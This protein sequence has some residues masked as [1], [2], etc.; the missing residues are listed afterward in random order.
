VTLVTRNCAINVSVT[1]AG[2]PL[3]DRLTFQAVVV[4]TI[5][6]AHFL[7]FVI[8]HSSFF[9]SSQNCLEKVKADPSFQ[10]CSWCIEDDPED[11]N[12]R[13]SNHPNTKIFGMTNKKIAVLNTK[14]FL[15][16]IN[17]GWAPD[18]FL[19]KPAY[20]VECFSMSGIKFEL[21]RQNGFTVRHIFSIGFSMEDFL[22]CYAKETISSEYLKEFVFLTNSS[23]AELVGA[24]ARVFQFSTHADILSY[25]N[26]NMELS[27]KE[28]LGLRESTPEILLDMMGEESWNRVYNTRDVSRLLTKMK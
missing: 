6:Q 22:V 18:S 24:V 12:R 9:F 10:I 14:K 27:L 20:G 28:L 19:S 2:S 13:V 11:T 25:L 23:F 17:R 4:V 26:N 7:P 1:G 21:L 15:R 5:K 16:L 3:S 8:D